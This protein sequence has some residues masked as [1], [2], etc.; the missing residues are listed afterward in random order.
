MN[1]FVVNPPFLKK[2][3][4][5]QRS[6]AVTKSGTLYFPIWLAYC[7]GMLKS[8]GFEV[9]FIDAP[10][11]DMDLSGVIA[12]MQE[13]EPGLAVLDTSTPSIFNDIAVAET[14]K[15][16][17]PRVFLVLVG[18]H[19]SA[20]PE[21]TMIASP[22]IDAVTRGEYDL[23]ILELAQ[24]LTKAEQRELTLE[25]LLDIPGLSVRLNDKVYHNEAREF[26]QDLDTLPWVSKVYKEYLDIR[27]YF[28]PNAYFPMVTLI[29]SRGCPFRCSFCLYPQTLTGRKF[30]FRSITDLVDEMEFVCKAFPSAKSIFFEDD[31][32]T[33][34]K[35]HCMA[36]SKEILQRG[37]K[38]TWTANSRVDLDYET[39]KMLR[40]AGCRMLCV[41]FES[42]DPEVLKAMRKGTSREQMLQFAGDARK[43]GILIH[44]CF[45]F[46]FPG[47]TQQSI[48]KTID[49][50]KELKPD[51]VQFYPVM[52]YPGTEAYEEY[53]QKGWITV[54]DY[55]QWITQDGL[56][57]CMIRNDS[58]E[59]E[60]I[61]RLCDLARKRFYLRPGYL[62]DRLQK[63]LRSRDEFI[64]SFKAGKTFFRH[65][66]LGSKV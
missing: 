2:Y 10:A 60:E 27:D 48:E 57:N 52:V 43:A 13:H 53:L 28:N 7:V 47:E 51:T 46:G 64:R 62:V 16:V 8:R 24:V 38:V 20:L 18:T 45:I 30:R 29:S 56:H 6:P 9:Q 14:I 5:P 1:I 26:V 59:P 22:A 61:V 34:K 4:R 66:L 65:L 55:R 31:T 54:S 39:M 35:S 23:T 15:Q 25:E 50:A 63:S 36:L 41:G 17:L 33:A 58:L 37:L 19:V 40:R 21:E 11:Q 49:F 32:L 12:L 42:G 44:G 3:S